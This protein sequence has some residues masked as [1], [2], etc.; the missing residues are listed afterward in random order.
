MNENRD[1]RGGQLSGSGLESAALCPGKPSAERGCPEEASPLAIA[2]TRM[3]SGFETGNLD[4]LSDDEQK[5]VQKAIR[6]RKNMVKEWHDLQCPDLF[7][8]SIRRQ[9]LVEKRLW[10]FDRKLSGKFDH[11]EIFAEAGLLLDLKTG[12]KEQVSVVKNIQ[13]RAYAVLCADAYGLKEVTVGI[14]Q[15]NLA[16][17]VTSVCVY[18]Q[19]S[20]E[21]ARNEIE[22]IIWR[23]SDPDARR[24]PG[25][26]QCRFC[27]AKSKCP[28]ARSVASELAKTK[29]EEITIEQLPD[30]LDACETAEKIIL[31]IR[32][33]AKE[34]LSVQGSI[35]GWFMKP[36]VVREKITDTELLFGRVHQR[37]SVDP[38]DFAAICDVSKTKLRALLKDH[39]TLKGKALEDAIGELLEGITESKRN[40][41]SLSREKGGAK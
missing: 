21:K 5:L 12:F 32:N 37:F 14:I 4:G 19:E 40:A 16:N 13:L 6:I 31:A 1:E 7:P 35:P 3:H 23:A 36:G 2:G 22:G 24:I 11:L 27:R 28:E 8:E 10:G 17:D 30:L 38:G 15:P 39:S 26:V 9:T 18:D 20:L 34:E 33:K 25:P 41:S 29:L